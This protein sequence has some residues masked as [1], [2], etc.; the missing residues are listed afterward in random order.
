VRPQ[1]VEEDV[2]EPG[3][4]G[5]LVLELAG[6]QLDGAVLADDGRVGIERAVVVEHPLSEGEERLE[7]GPVRL[8]VLDH[9]GLLSAAL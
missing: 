2:Q 1:R 3:R 4:M 5:C 6:H 9:P 8:L 7:Q